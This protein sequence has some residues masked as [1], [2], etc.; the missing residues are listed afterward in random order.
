MI[1]TYLPAA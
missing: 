1:C